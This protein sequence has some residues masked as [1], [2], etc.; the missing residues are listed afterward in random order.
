ML[1]RSRSPYGIDPPEM[2]FLVFRLMDK[3]STN[4]DTHYLDEAIG[5]AK[6]AVKTLV[7]GPLSVRLMYGEG[8]EQTYAGT[9]HLQIEVT[10]QA[11]NP[12]PTF[13]PIIPRQ[14]SSLVLILEIFEQC[15]SRLFNG[16]SLY[17]YNIITGRNL[18]RFIPDCKP[19]PP[20]I[21]HII[22]IPHV[23]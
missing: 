22:R 8:E 7:R 10:W 17:H 15:D 1:L 14:S 19:H 6:V 16:I 2:Q 12:T 20:H 13:S 3:F 5:V 23:V 11:K 21:L 4:L 9:L 18:Y